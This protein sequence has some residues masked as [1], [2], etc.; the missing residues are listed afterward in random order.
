[1]PAKDQMLKTVGRAMEEFINKGNSKV[2]DEICTDDYVW[3]PG[4]VASAMYKEM[5]QIDHQQLR[6]AFPNLRMQV[7]DMVADGDKVTTHFTLTGVHKGPLVDRTRGGVTM[8]G[9][10]RRIT[11]SGVT[12]HRITDDGKIAEGWL[13]YDRA[14]FEQQLGPFP[15]R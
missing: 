6:N 10:G 14:G 15:P 3:H 5:H 11:W 12:V 8:M 9:S 7:N 13:N 4:D 1:M 2:L